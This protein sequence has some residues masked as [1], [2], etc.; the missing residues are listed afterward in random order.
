MAT[1]HPVYPSLLMATIGVSFLLGPYLRVEIL[2]H[3]VNSRLTVKLPNRFPLWLNYFT[4]LS[5]MCEDSSSSA[6]SQTF[7]VV[8][9]LHPHCFSK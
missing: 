2:S 9:V 8:S 3:V 5:T 7:G 4:F 6:A 1:P